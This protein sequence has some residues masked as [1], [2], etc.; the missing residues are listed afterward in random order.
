MSSIFC[1]KPIEDLICTLFSTITQ[2]IR[3]KED[4]SIDTMIPYMCFNQCGMLM[5]SDLSVSAAAVSIFNIFQNDMNIEM[6]ATQISLKDI[7]LIGLKY[8]LIFFEILRFQTQ[9]KR[10]LFGDYFWRGRKH[11][12]SKL[13]NLGEV[14]G[15]CMYYMLHASYL[16]LCFIFI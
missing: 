1:F 9:L 15:N 7:I 10:S 5:L 4:L 2:S 11:L 3:Q 16:Y 8:P 6:N 12:P 14:T 13:H